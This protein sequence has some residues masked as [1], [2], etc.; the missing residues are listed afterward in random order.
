[1]L[2]LRLLAAVP[3]PRPANPDYCVATAAVA[4][5]RR[6]DVSTFDANRGSAQSLLAARSD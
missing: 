6:Q 5:Y 2:Q 3:A 4:G 1:M